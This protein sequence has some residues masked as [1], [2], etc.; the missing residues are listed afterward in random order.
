MLTGKQHFLKKRKGGK[1]L[2]ATK[3]YTNFLEEKEIPI[4]IKKI[5]NLY[6]EKK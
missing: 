3:Y 5:I 4:S 2:E 1:N 6:K